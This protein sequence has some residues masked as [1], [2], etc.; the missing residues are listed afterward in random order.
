MKLEIEVPDSTIQKIA[1]TA[2]SDLFRL[3]GYSDD[4]GG[5]Q[6]VKQ[7]VYAAVRSDEFTAHVRELVRACALRIKESIVTDIVA[8]TLRKEV[9]QVVKQE[10][11]KGTLFDR[12]QAP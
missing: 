5:V 2:V 11:T 12:E 3:R 1:D 10:K 8:E 4:G 6:I 9:R 7:A